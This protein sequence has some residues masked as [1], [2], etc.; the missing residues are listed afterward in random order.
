MKKIIDFSERVIDIVNFIREQEGHKTFIGALHSIV[1][2]YYNKFYFSKYKGKSGSR[3]VIDSALT[4]EKLTPEQI[5][6]K[7]GGKVVTR[8]GNLMC[9]FPE[10]ALTRF[11]PIDTL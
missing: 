3:S 5:C 4:E 8:N 1:S 10:G 11:V 2:S 6:E 9:A 7:K